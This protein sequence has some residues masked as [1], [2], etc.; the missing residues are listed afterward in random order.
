LTEVFLIEGFHDIHNGNQHPN[1]N[2]K[3]KGLTPAQRA[4]HKLW[5]EKYWRHRANQ[6]L[7]RQGKI[8]EF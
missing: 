7:I 3:G 2:A 4:E 1:G 6:E 8:P 5:T